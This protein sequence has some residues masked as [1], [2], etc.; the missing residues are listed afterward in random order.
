MAMPEAPA[1]TQAATTV[2]TEGGGNVGS[3]S[4][5]TKSTTM[6]DLHRDTLLGKG[7]VV[8]RLLAWVFSL[9]SL[10]VMAS[11]KHGDGKNFDQYDEYRLLP[12]CLENDNLFPTFFMT[13]WLPNSKQDEGTKKEVS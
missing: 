11:N 13:T 8:L 10:V 2:S 6:G 4:N 7:M 3:A 12:F 1:T 5:T 9:L